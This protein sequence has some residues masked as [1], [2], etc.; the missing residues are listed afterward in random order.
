[1]HCR[2]RRLIRRSSLAA[3][4]A[5]FLLT[6]LAPVVGQTTSGSVGG[7]VRDGQGAPIPGAA[8][9]LL[10]PRRGTS[11]TLKAGPSGDFV[12][13]TVTPDEYTLQITADGFRLVERRAVVVNANDR[14]SVGVFTLEVGRAE[15]VTVTTVTIAPCRTARSCWARTCPTSPP[16]STCPA[17]VTA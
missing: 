7:S 9:T 3:A 10:C 11:Q 12:F 6:P 14:V 5:S 8:V 2:V 16:A 4:V 17:S 13:P 15:D 1:M